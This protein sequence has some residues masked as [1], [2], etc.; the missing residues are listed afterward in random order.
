MR[1][2]P[3]RPNPNPNPNPNWILTEQAK[4]SGKDDKVIAKMVTGRLNKFYTE[5]CLVD[6]LFLAGDDPKQTVAKYLK[7]EAKSL[8][9]AIQPVAYERFQCGEGI[10]KEEEDYAAEVAKMSGVGS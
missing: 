1:S 8:N 5:F 4:S 10:E 6:Q 9:A 3:S 7:Q 2:S